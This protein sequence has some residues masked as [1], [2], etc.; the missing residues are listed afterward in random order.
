MLSKEENELITRTGPG[1]PMG[2]AIRRYWVPA[3]LSSELPERDGDPIRVRLLG[4]DLVAFRD[5]QGRIGLL[6]ENCPHRGAALYLGRNEEGGLR[7]LYHGWKMD[8]EGKVLDTPCEPPESVVRFKA[9]ARAYAVHEQ[10]DVV[11]AYMGPPDKQPPF[12]DYQW[13]LV[14]APN[15]SVKKV[16]EECNWVQSLEGSMDRSHN[17]VLHDGRDI[18]RYP[19]DQAHLREQPRKV[20]VV[21]TRYGLFH[22]ATQP[23]RKDPDHL[24]TVSARPFA[25]PFTSYVAGPRSGNWNEPGFE[26]GNH[27]WGVHIFV[28]VDDDNN[29]YYEVRYHPNMEVDQVEETRF[30]VVGVDIDA[31]GRKT[32]RRLENHYLQDRE[33]MRARRTFSGIDGRPHE[34]MSM[35]ES[36]GRIYDRTQEHLGLADVVTIRLRQRLLDTANEVL[37]GR[38]P[39]GL[40][41]S[42]PYERLASFTR[43]IGADRPWQEAEPDMGDP[44]TDRGQAV[45]AGER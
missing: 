41:P 5:T 25:L 34:D 37:E 10:G 28:P 26:E 21:N 7:C 18:M 31:E 23:D 11:W 45:A 6:P 2:E 35:I 14:P 9:R 24:K 32:K 33:A 4:E 12:P 27:P 44:A 1:T 38:D 29:L 42:I 36:M 19:D 40:D 39:P 15:R 20:E 43:V 3:C 8:I 16:L 13:T 17:V 22:V 30:L